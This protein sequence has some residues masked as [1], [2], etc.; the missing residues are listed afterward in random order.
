ML[1]SSTFRL[2]FFA[3]VPQTPEA[4]PFVAVI[5]LLSIIVLL[6]RFLAYRR[7][8][9]EA[10]QIEEIIL[11]H[12]KDPP[13]VLS[14]LSAAAAPR[15]ARRLHRQMEINPETNRLI[16]RSE[17]EAGRC[18]VRRIGTDAKTSSS[19]PPP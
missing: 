7:S 1:E 6:G 15:L 8:S 14:R 18:M 19:P 16:L 12:G 17:P 2:F 5:L 11:T 10:R 9:Q 3:F 13:Q 4:W